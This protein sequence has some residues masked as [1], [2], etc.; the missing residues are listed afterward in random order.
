ML[1][2][3]LIMVL[4]LLSASVAF[5][6]PVSEDQ[7]SNVTQLNNTQLNNTQLNVMQF[8]EILPKEEGFSVS[9]TA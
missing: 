9:S 2:S 8:E 1:K 7:N 4:L 3:I 6:S 5:A